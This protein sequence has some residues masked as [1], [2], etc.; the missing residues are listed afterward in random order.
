MHNRQ[1]IVFG[2][3]PGSGK[4]TLARHLGRRVG[5][6]HL[7][8]DTIE[9]AMIRAGQSVSGPEGYIVACAVA[10]DNLRLGHSV[11]VDSVNPIEITRDLYRGVAVRAEVPIAEVE[12]VCGDAKEHRERVE[13]RIADIPG[14]KLPSWQA[15]LDRTYDPWPE[16]LTIDT[17]ATSPDACIASLI[18]QLELRELDIC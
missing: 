15:V 8:I 6:I 10:E 17:A 13:T 2:G 3:L 16:A 12:I 14:H 1:L 4:S 7:R 5:A 18:D 11:I 9:Q